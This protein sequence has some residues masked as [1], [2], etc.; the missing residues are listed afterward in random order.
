VGAFFLLR[1]NDHL[2]Y[3]KKIKSTLDGVGDFRGCDHHGCKLGGWID[4]TGPAEAAEVGP[5][6]TAVLDSVVVFHER[7][8][9]A[10]GLALQCRETGQR[11]E[12]ESRVTEMH[13]LSG[14][15]VELLLE[16]DRLAAGTK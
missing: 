5:E 6:A 11:A 4:G 15:L 10:S 12:S 2:Q 14:T 7:F 3:L 13:R 16:L 9:Q 8:H 1:M